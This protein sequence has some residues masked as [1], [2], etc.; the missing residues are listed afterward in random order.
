MNMKCS[1]CAKWHIT[2]SQRGAGGSSKQGGGA[3]IKRRNINNVR[4]DN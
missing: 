3:I 1:S 2:S 4:T